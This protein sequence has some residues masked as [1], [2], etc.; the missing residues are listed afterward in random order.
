MRKL[1]LGLLF[2]VLT[3][4]AF[5]QKDF[6]VY[7]ENTE[8][9]GIEVYADNN[10]FC[11][12]S[13]RLSFELV[14]MK[15]SKGNNRIFAVPARSKKVPLTQITQI[16]KGK[17]KFSYKT[18]YNYGN[19]NLTNYDKDFKY[20]LPFEKGQS[21]EVSQGYNGSF[22]HQGENALDFKMDIGTKVMA[23]RKGTVVRVIDTNNKTCPKK[24]CEKYNNLILIYHS[25]GTF[26]KYAHIKKNGAKVKVGDVVKKGQLIAESGNVGRSTGP[27]LHLVIFL[28][29]LEERRTLKTMFLKDEGN[30]TGFLK[31][32]NTYSKIYD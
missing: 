28:Q 15:S 21:F 23:V 32:K 10:E 27:H 24:D 5:A 30:T 26:A 6:K 25:D 29:K 22:S 17:F 1:V 2:T 9:G 18:R 12:I 13:V 8:D 31:E 19:H 4:K 14:N 11:P 16:R 3:L 20:F 7:F